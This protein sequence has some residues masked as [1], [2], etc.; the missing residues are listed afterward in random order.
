MHIAT[1]THGHKCVDTIRT[2]NLVVDIE[3]GGRGGARSQ[4]TSEVKY[5]LLLNRPKQS[6]TV[7]ATIRNGK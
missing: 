1:Y 3:M 4:A 2:Q 7:N 6:K 5:I